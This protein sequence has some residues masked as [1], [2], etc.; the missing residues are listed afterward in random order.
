MLQMKTLTPNAHKI[1]KY[2][3][4][5]LNTL[6][7]DDD[8]MQRDRI[9]NACLDVHRST[10]DDSFTDVMSDNA[11]V[12]WRACKISRFGKHKNELSDEEIRSLGNNLAG[13]INYALQDIGKAKAGLTPREEESFDDARPIRNKPKTK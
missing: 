6:T 13:F 1:A 7:I 11:L 3:I 2:C 5:A 10:D 8:K 12:A 9:L 4:A